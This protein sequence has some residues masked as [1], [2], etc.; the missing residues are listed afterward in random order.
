[1]RYRVAFV[2]GMGCWAVVLKWVL[3]DGILE[4]RWLA[5]AALVVPTLLAP[6]VLWWL[7]RRRIAE[8][9][10]MLAEIRAARNDAPPTGPS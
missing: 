9:E 4:G 6:V 10:A 5:T 3:L 8:G 2:V 7:R 1:M